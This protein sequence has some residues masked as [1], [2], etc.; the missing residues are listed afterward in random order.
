[1]GYHFLELDNA[2]RNH[3]IMFKIS[4]QFVP[5]GFSLIFLRRAK[6]FVQFM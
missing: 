6:D 5:Q 3:E 4:V 2:Y 1:M